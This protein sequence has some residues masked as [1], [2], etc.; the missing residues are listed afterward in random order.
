MTGGLEQFSEQLKAFGPAG[1]FGIA[2]LDATFIPLPLILDAAMISLSFAT[3]ALMPVNALAA[4]LG[5]TLGCL[6]LYTI[7]RKAGA[8]ALRRFPE[9]KRERVKGLI[10]R[11]DVL[12]VFAVSLLPPPFPFK[13]FVVT[14][15]VFRFNVV[16]FV[17][18]IAA[19]RAVRFFLEGFLAVRYGERAGKIFQENFPVIGIGVAALAV[20]F[21]VLRGLLKKRKGRT[22]AES[23]EVEEG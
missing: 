5:S 16:R 9:K 15:G 11:Y 13:L 3:P 12:S 10:D 18:A 22:V 6:V 20:L 2:F 23:A 1:L 4:T 17:S 19:G 21:F 7:S 14:A 8:G